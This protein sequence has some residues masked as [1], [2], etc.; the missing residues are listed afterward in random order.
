MNLMRGFFGVVFVSLVLFLFPLNSSAA[1]FEKQAGYTVCFTPGENC[2]GEIVDVINNAVNNIWVQ[3]YSFTSRPIAKALIVAKERGVNVQIIMDKEALSGNKG[4][5][6]FFTRSKIPVWIDKQPAIAHSKVMVIDQTRVITGSFNFTR[7]A[8]QQNAENLLIID[9]ENLAKKYLAN[10]KNRQ[11]V[12]EFYKGR[13]YTTSDEPSSGFGSF[14]QWL[15][16]LF[17]RLFS[18]GKH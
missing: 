14:W 1:A 8:Q 6:R 4:I 10:W 13:V 17:E 9:D 18:I 15:V 16:N 2:T 7:A 11:Q 5:L 3:A 12:S